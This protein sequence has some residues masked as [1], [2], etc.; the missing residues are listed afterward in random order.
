M[1]SVPRIFVLT[2][3]VLVGCGRPSGDPDE[4]IGT[5]RS[6]LPPATLRLGPR[7]F[8]FQ[9]GQ[10]TK[11]GTVERTPFRMAFVLERTSSPAFDLYCRETVD[12]YDWSLEDGR[13]TFRAVGSPCDRAAR[14]VL[15]AG[16]WT[17][18]AR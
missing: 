12:V 9:S 10:L 4:L 1:R 16:E 18:A 13:L 3:L 14:T 7:S 2:L 15:V 17:R 11:W 8:E 5:W 6:R